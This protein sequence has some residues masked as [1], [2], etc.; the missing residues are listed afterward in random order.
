M[1]FKELSLSNF[2]KFQN[3]TLQFQKGLNLIIGQNESGKSTL[4]HALL[5]I[6]FGFKA[7]RHRY[8]PWQNP[9][10]YQARLTLQTPEDEILLERDF[11]EDRVTLMQ[12]NTTTHQLSTFQGKISPQGRSSE[13]EVYLNKIQDLFGFSDPEIFKN[14]LFIEQRSLHLPP[15]SETRAELKQL[16]SNI[17]EFKYDDIIARLEERYF[18]LTKKNPKG[19]DKRNDRLL[20]ELQ[21]QIGEFEQ[22]IEKAR[23][24]QETLQKIS[25]KLSRLKETLSLKEQRLKILTQSISAREQLLK[26]FRKEAEVKDSLS[27]LQKRKS[28]VERLTEHLST[29]QKTKPHMNRLTI[30][31][32]IVAF[33]TLPMIFFSANI[34]LLWL[35]LLFIAIS[36]F[37]GHTIYQQKQ[38]AQHFELQEMR[39]RSQLEVLPDIKKLDFSIQHH[40]KS[41]FEMD[42]Q[43]SELERAVIEEHKPLP[44]HQAEK[45]SLSRD[46]QDLKET[47]ATEKQNTLYLSKGLESPFTL[48]EDL[49]DLKQKEKNLKIKAQALWTAK[50]ML[51]Q[52]VIEFRKEHLKLFAK[53]TESLFHQISSDGYEQFSFDEDFLV[54]SL[55][56]KAVTSPISTSSLSCGT[57]DQLYF[58][59]KL[60]L[61][62]LLSSGRGLPLFLDDPFVNFDHERR[63]KVLEFLKTCAMEHQIFLFTYDQWYAEHIKECNII[64]LND[65]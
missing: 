42:A 3:K 56:S 9:S 53:D 45:E 30:G 38:T 49:F 4:F 63:V 34:G 47:Y 39:L 62:K 26:L 8:L 32:L 22:R 33:F 11:L 46:I 48:E 40:Q 5:G 24:G 27:D 17:S 19:I 59:M 21:K 16:I 28:L 35:I 58:A 50:E 13:R 65:S 2:G 51:A 20:E 61:L 7:D 52:M 25:E 54:P 23:T 44:E 43:K 15:S 14:S 12:K 6:V 36:L 31:L 60:S 10:H 18:E 41:L 64:K 37:L 57:Q 55:R 29:L 1:I